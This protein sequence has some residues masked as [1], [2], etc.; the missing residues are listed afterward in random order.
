ML[1]YSFMIYMCLANYANVG[2][3][4][5]GQSRWNVILDLKLK[6]ILIYYVLTYRMI[7]TI[8]L[9]VKVP[10]LIHTGIVLSDIDM[11][12]VV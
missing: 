5:I 1:Y 8:L 3:S 11:H 6:T 12:W 2:H 4:N 9:I 7:L 10:F